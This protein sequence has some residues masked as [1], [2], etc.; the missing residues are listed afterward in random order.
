MALPWNT[1]KRK[2]S[3]AESG[4]EFW[5]R[6]FANSVKQ[7]AFDPLLGAIWERIARLTGCG[8]K[9]G[10]VIGATDRSAGEPIERPAGT[11]MCW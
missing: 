5:L 2:A 4:D 1:R 11:K 9:M 10:Q 7:S 6:K 8:M 3:L